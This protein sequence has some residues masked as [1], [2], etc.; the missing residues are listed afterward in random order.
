M[1][2]QH[3]ELGA[4]SAHRWMNC[5]ASI[6]LSRGLPKEASSPAALAGTL[7]HARLEKVFGMYVAQ[8]HLSHLP[9]EFHSM[10]DQLLASELRALDALVGLWGGIKGP[11]IAFIEEKVDLTFLQPGM[12]GTCDYYFYAPAENKLYVIDFKNGTNDVEVED[13]SQ[14]MFYALGVLHKYQQIPIGLWEK[15]YALTVELIIIQPNS[16]GELVKRQTKTSEEIC[17]WAHTLQDAAIETTKNTPKIAAGDWCIYCPAKDTC[18][19]LAR[20]IVEKA[21]EAVK[22]VPYISDIPTEALT[23]FVKSQEVIENSFSVIKQEIMKRIADGEEVEGFEVRTRNSARRWQSEEEV[24]KKFKKYGE[25]L[26]QPRK[27]KSPTQLEEL[28]LQEDKETYLDLQADTG[29]I[30]VLKDISKPRKARGDKA[31]DKSKASLSKWN[32][33]KGYVTTE[34]DEFIS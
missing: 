22:A 4:S 19:L 26:Y 6:K 16:G 32:K 5:P 15:P 14:L 23:K 34:E 10:K 27:L 28:I 17:A 30:Y 20:E 25:E 12:F 9:M 29:E 31:D 1:T 8:E 3:S 33:P 18:P 2:I 24:I 11:K 7:A 21:P 13:N